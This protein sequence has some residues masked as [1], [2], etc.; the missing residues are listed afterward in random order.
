MDDFVIK[1]LLHA[2]KSAEPSLG[3]PQAAP[4][5]FQMLVSHSQHRASTD[6][7]TDAAS[8]TLTDPTDW[9]PTWSGKHCWLQLPPWGSGCGDWRHWVCRRLPTPTVELALFYGCDRRQASRRSVWRGFVANAPS[10][11]LRLRAVARSSAHLSPSASWKSAAIWAGTSTADSPAARRASIGNSRWSRSVRAVRAATVFEA[12]TG[13][14]ATLGSM[15]CR[16]AAACFFASA[17]D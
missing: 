14:V 4:R 15:S 13:A 2:K 11:P 10:A 5:W 3:G 1:S 6:G 12:D 9:V 16:V 8:I 17:F 7:R